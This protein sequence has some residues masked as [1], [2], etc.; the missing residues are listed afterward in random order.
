LA[1]RILIVDDSFGD[2]MVLRDTLASLGYRVVGDA[3]NIRD[4]VE[5]YKSLKPDLVIMDVTIPE[6][7]A[8][9]GIT[10]LLREDLEANVLVSVTRGQ[11]MLAMEAIQAG[12]KDFVTKPF[13]MRALHRTIRSIIG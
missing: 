8:V 10:Q 12:A 5:K 4:S 11:R 1:K 13:N 7:D 6:R 9:A 3:R 2:R